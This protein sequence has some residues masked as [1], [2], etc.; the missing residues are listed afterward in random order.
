MSEMDKMIHH[1]GQDGTLAHLAQTDVSSCPSL[2][3]YG[4]KPLII[5]FC[6]QVNKSARK[7]TNIDVYTMY[8]WGLTE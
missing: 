3:Q 2:G 8:I 6:D 7:W 4:T 1:W 5:F